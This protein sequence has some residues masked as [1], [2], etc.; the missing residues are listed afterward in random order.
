[1]PYVVMVQFVPVAE[2][3]WLTVPRLAGK[4]AFAPRDMAAVF[5][6]RAGADAA[7]DELLGTLQAHGATF[8]VQE[9][10]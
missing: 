1:M 8:T 4:R 5:D 3:R 7:A 9:I 6:T 10:D 2:I